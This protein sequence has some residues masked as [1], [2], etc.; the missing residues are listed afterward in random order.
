[1]MLYLLYF[2]YEKYWN[3]ALQ[4]QEKSDIVGR[5]L[6]RR[7]L[8][9]SD[10]PRRTFTGKITHLTQDFGIFENFIY[11]PCGDSQWF[12]E[13]K[14]G[15]EVHVTAFCDTYFE[16]CQFE[17]LELKNDPVNDLTNNI[18][19]YCIESFDNDRNLYRLKDGRQIS[20]NYVDSQYP[21]VPG[22]WLR[23]TSSGT[24]SLFSGSSENG[25]AEPLR[26]I[27]CFS[28][29]AETA[30]KGFVTKNKVSRF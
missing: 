29:V 5:Y 7:K 3:N 8:V 19:I 30:R 18:N 4:N 23:I 11:F 10:S 12:Q 14:V 25:T 26:T 15:D 22:D 28:M 6:E 2:L 13:L 21:V 9:F 27:T 20:A 17:S 16:N 1:M 24:S